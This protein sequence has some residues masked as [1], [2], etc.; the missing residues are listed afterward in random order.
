MSPMTVML[1]V[2]LRWFGSLSRSAAATHDAPHARDDLAEVLLRDLAF[3]VQVVF[4]H[5]DVVG[6]SSAEPTVLFVQEE[7]L[8]GQRQVRRGPEG[9]DW[10]VSLGVAQWLHS[11]IES[12]LLREK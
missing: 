12:G 3:P 4:D 5:P 7:V 11:S 9:V 10:A 2:R 1:S 8:A 6:A